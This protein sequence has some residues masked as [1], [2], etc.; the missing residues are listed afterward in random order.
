[1]TNKNQKR[2]NSSNQ[3]LEKSFTHR[4]EIQRSIRR[5][6]W[7]TYFKSLA[8]RGR[9]HGGSHNSGSPAPVFPVSPDSEQAYIEN[10]P[11]TAGFRAQPTRQNGPTSGSADNAWSSQT[12]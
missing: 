9:N 4:P 5:K 7:M 1:M 11:Q 6:I 2:A 12:N 3:M 10:D 8:W